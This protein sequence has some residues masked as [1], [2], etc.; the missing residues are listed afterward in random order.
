MLIQEQFWWPEIDGDVHW[1]VGTCHNCQI[2]QNTV[3]NRAPT[4]TYTPSI[5]QT[6][7]IDTMHMTP[8]LDGC[9]YIVH[10][11]C[12]AEIITDNTG[13][14]KKRPHW[15]VRQALFKA[16]EDC[17]KWFWFFFHVMWSDCITIQ[18]RFEWSPYFMVTGA[19]PTLPLDL[20]EA[21]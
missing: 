9:K 10:G 17:T 1:Y 2:C 20:V 19:H 12:I 4:V 5:F 11:S 14:F 16:S 3:V 21:I 6:I 7:H 8:A 13:Q 15:D 18:Q